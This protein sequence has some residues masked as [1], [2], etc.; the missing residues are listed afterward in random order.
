MDF[1]SARG[2]PSG[3]AA[4]R[5]GTNTTPVHENALMSCPCWLRLPRKAAAP[6]SHR[7]RMHSLSSGITASIAPPAV[8]SRQKFI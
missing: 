1:L 7:R 8:I 3:K 6:F 2:E 5:S 4:R